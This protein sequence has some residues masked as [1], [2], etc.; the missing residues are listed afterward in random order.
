MRIP[1]T[2]VLD[3]FLPDAHTAE[4]P[5]KQGEVDRSSKTN[6]FLEP[7]GG[8]WTAH[9]AQTALM[10]YGHWYSLKLSYM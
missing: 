5:E 7:H 8:L 3:T 2:Y 4:L 1:D 6:L 10:R 9:S